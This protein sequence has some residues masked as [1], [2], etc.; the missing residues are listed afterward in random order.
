MLVDVKDHQNLQSHAVSFLQLDDEKSGPAKVLAFLTQ[1]AQIL[2]S[3]VLS[4]L[5]LK[6]EVGE[7]K[8]HFV[9]VRSLI[10]DLIEKLEADAEA[11]ETQK[12]FCDE[13]MGEAVDD[14]DTAIGAIEG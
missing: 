8:D 2:K 11:E 13:K 10:K 4:T 1:K 12:T 5:A 14:R 3:P 7:G 9:K 6:L